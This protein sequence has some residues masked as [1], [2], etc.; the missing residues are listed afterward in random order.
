MSGRSF[1]VIMPKKPLALDSPVTCMPIMKL[2]EP[3][4]L[5]KMEA[6]SIYATSCPHCLEVVTVAVES[7]PKQRGG[8]G[9]SPQGTGSG[10]NSSSLSNDTPSDTGIPAHTESS[11]QPSF[12]DISD[13]SSDD[14]SDESSTLFDSEQCSL[15]D[16]FDPL[17]TE[18]PIEREPIDPGQTPAHFDNRLKKVRTLQKQAA[19]TV[20]YYTTEL[21]RLSEDVD[22][23]E[24]MTRKRRENRVRGLLK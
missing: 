17:D 22:R 1:S 16:L 2:E 6:G 10:T 19:L 7:P 13:T 9:T 21:E 4:P 8:M 12:A 20:Y 14:S 11:D 5:E 3:L 18:L 15:S 24:R 23:L